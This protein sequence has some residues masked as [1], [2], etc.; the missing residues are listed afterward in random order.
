MNNNGA[1]YYVGVIGMEMESD[2]G[3]H[4]GYIKEY[5]SGVYF[6]SSAVESMISI[7]LCN[8]KTGFDRRRNTGNTRMIL[9][10]A[11]G[12]HLTSGTR[13]SGLGS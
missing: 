4:H 5:Y 3:D 2:D 13:S 7:Y 12:S 10:P 9:I 11:T 8:R 6:I 1:C